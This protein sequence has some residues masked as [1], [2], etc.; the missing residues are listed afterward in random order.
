MELENEVEIYWRFIGIICSKKYPK[1]RHKWGDK[2]LITILKSNSLNYE[3]EQNLLRLY[4]GLISEN[5][6]PTGKQFKSLSSRERKKVKIT[7]HKLLE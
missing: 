4:S 5:D 6:I 7:L 3:I 2:F 1:Y